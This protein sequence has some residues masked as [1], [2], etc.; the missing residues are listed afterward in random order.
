MVTFDDIAVKYDLWE[1]TPLG[2]LCVRLEKEIL[3][4]M[5][6]SIPNRG[7]VLDAG[8]GTGNNAVLLAQRGMSV[9]GVDISDKMLQVA[10]SKVVKAGLKVNLIQADAS[11]LPLPD[12]CF[13]TA[14][15]SLV[16]E[17]AENPEMIV[18][19]LFRVLRPKGVIILSFLNKNSYWTV[20]RKIS[21]KT[22]LSVYSNARFLGQKEVAAI[23]DGA[24]FVDPTW[25]RA[26]YFPPINNKV[27]LK[28]YR[29]FE[30]LGANIFPGTASFIAVRASKG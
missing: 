3:L 14:I 22:K 7:P 19:E 30:I 5:V 21:T 6:G 24:G 9:T 12:N 17:F 8:C 1:A 18:R 26:I 2:E 25:K 10:R 4:S 13:D 27:L 23:L 20:F 29:A 16:L 28:Y 15:C 11:K